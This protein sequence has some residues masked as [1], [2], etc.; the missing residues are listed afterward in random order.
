MGYVGT[1]LLGAVLGFLGGV[2]GIGGGIFVIPILGIFFGL[3]EQHAQ[4]TSLVM[5]VPNVAIGLYSYAK[6]GFDKRIA[7][8]LAI[9]AFPLTFVGTHVATHVPSASLRIAFAIF[10][11]AVA[12]QSLWRTFAMKA[13][14]PART[15]LPWPFASALG[16][17]G[18]FFSGVF[19]VGGSIFAVPLISAMFAVSQAT[20]Q[21]LGLALVAPGTLAAIAGYGTAGDI[22]W[23]TGIALAIGGV[24]AV[25]Y[26]VRVAHK[27]P[28]RT[29]RFI[30]AG[31]I[32]VGA[33]GLLVRA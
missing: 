18:G 12:V 19:S 27:L 17:V 25:P 32:V 16:A 23:P 2:F 8:A 11:F 15:P 3:D 1:A 13:D 30:F 29:L 33:V 6:R 7:F 4:G 20:A 21:G 28:D 14:A 26:G 31:M 5:V 9:A 10:L 22:D 24:F